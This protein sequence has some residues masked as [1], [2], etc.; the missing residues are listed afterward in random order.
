MGSDCL[1]LI[2]GIW[3]ELYGDDP[4]S[5]PQY[6]RDWGESGAT[7]CLLK[8]VSNVFDSVIMGSSI[9]PG[10]VLVFRMR[11]GSVT[12]HLGVVGDGDPHATFIHSYSGRAVH[13]TALSTPWRH[14]LAGRFAFPAPPN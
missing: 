6:S 8:A 10:Q 5:I 13:E 2:R 4:V 11:R 12:K 3:H 14:R 7:D 9:S 1:G